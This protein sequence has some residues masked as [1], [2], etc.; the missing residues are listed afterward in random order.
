MRLPLALFWQPA[1]PARRLAVRRLPANYQRGAARIQR[2]PATVSS[3]RDITM[4]L[5]QWRQALTVSWM[6]SPL[7][8]WPDPLTP[9]LQFVSLACCYV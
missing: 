1:R 6:R 4:G 8:F 5:R 7:A 9:A 2:I 3:L